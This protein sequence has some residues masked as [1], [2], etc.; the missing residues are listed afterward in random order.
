MESSA[1]R[2]CMEAVFIDPPDEFGVPVSSLSLSEMCRKFLVVDTSLDKG[3]FEIPVIARAPALEVMRKENG[4]RRGTNRTVIPLYST[5]TV[6]KRSA[7]L[8]FQ[9]I[10]RLGTF[11]QRLI[12]IITSKGQTYYGG[13]GILLDADWNPLML[14]TLMA[15]RISDLNSPSMELCFYKAILHVS[16]KVFLNQTDLME[17]SIIKKVIPFYL[18]NPL[19]MALGGRGVMSE[20]L[21]TVQIEVD[22]MSRFFHTPVI[23][24]PDTYS[25]EEMNRILAEHAGEIPWE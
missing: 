3:E 15:R 14:A 2:N 17:K 23:P 7:D 4:E 16:P 9:Y 20:C 22:D 12:K 13:Y 1:Y 19:G 8:I 18:A 21:G 24:R 6:R 11:N 25:D 10:V 5:A